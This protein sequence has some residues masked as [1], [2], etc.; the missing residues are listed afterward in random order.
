MVEFSDRPVSVT[1]STLSPLLN[2]QFRITHVRGPSAGKQ[3]YL[4]P[5]PSYV[6][7]FTIGFCSSQWCFRIVVGAFNPS[8][9]FSGDTSKRQVAAANCIKLADVWLCA[10]VQLMAFV[11]V[12]RGL[13][14]RS[15][16][17]TLHSGTFRLLFQQNFRLG[18]IY[19]R[20]VVLKSRQIGSISLIVKEKILMKT[21]WRKCFTTLEPF[22]PFS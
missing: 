21:A 2:P 12:V 11:Y 14:A 6:N 7:T 20:A 18:N 15:H 3:T 4:Q 1:D 16:L 10:C 8:C 22:K 9:Y 13:C 17:E 19:A 5:I